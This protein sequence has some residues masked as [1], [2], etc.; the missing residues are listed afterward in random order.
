[1]ESKL[2]KYIRDNRQKFID[3]LR[4]FLQQP[5]IAAEGIGGEEGARLVEQYLAKRN[6]KTRRLPNPGNPVI[7]GE[8]EG[9][10]DKTV[11]LYC[12]YDVQP[13]GSESDWQYPPFAA[14][15]VGDRLWGRGSGDHK[16]CLLSRIQALEAVMAVYGKPAPTVKFLL[17]ADEET[18]SPY[19]AKVM[20]EN[21]NLL[22]ADGSLYSGRFK[23]PEGRPM[24]A[25]GGSGSCRIRLTASGANVNL[26]PM[27]ATLVSNP[28]L[29]LIRAVSLI[30]DDSQ[31]ITV[32]GVR[33]AVL[34]PTKEDR[35]V[36][37]NFP[38]DEEGIKKSLGIDSFIANLTGRE[39]VMHQ[40]FEPRVMVAGIETSAGEHLIPSVPASASI[41]LGFSLFVDQEPDT[42]FE[43]IRSHL[44]SH[45]F[46]DLRI[47]LLGGKPPAKTPIADPLVQ[48]LISA[49]KAT[50]GQDPVVYPTTLGAGP[51]S[52]FIKQNGIPMA[53]D[54]GV[55]HSGSN[56]HAPNENIYLS[57]YF[58]GLE[59]M[60]RFLVSYK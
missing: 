48:S 25:A 44:I 26:H 10:S 56:Y 20:E 37:E 31:R 58:Q 9:E 50:Y 45:G 7:Y 40:F 8:V 12:H 18:G 29:R 51:W 54:P 28:I 38:L 4:E 24:I 11:L 30:V 53:S 19:L 55:A 15:L 3:E 43:Q 2:A 23:D 49:A 1:V 42:V 35:E 33:E 46:G 22:K 6:V 41:T 13:I 47:E 21:R 60:A 16:G 57:D 5:T 27:N 39:A 32:P 17:E 52:L 14:T 59:C 36:L 34:E